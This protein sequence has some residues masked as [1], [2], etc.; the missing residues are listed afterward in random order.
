MKKRT[1]NEKLGSAVTPPVAKQLSPS[2]SGFFFDLIPDIVIIVSA[3]W[4]A[5]SFVQRFHQPI[6]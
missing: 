2:L 6:V 5:C 3:C 1:L 4:Q